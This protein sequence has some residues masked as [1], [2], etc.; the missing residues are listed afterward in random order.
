MLGSAC[1]H[2]C[3]RDTVTPCRRAASLGVTRS[4][5]PSERERSNQP[6]RCARRAGC[7]ETRL[8][9]STEVVQSNPVRFRS[10]PAILSDGAS[11]LRQGDGDRPRS[12]LPMCRRVRA[13]P[14]QLKR[15]CRAVPRCG[16]VANPA[17]GVRAEVAECGLIGWKARQAR[18][19]SASVGSSRRGDTRDRT[20]DRVRRS[21]Q[22]KL[23]FSVAV[24]LVS[25]RSFF[26]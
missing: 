17:E 4:Y 24:K 2:F 11:P 25:H 8:S 26:G 19:T 21:A 1:R 9:R 20:R 6:R 12:G 16:A 7:V 22:S 23:C 13:G 15:V 5:Q 18:S 14:Q 3:Q 10:N